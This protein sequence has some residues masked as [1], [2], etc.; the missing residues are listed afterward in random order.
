MTE[1]V[2]GLLCLRRGDTVCQ[3]EGGWELSGDWRRAISGMFN[4]TRFDGAT[5]VSYQN[6]NYLP[7]SEGVGARQL[8]IEIE[9]I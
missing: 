8:P 3:P 9:V 7:R 1:C 4:L 5:T 2:R 6:H